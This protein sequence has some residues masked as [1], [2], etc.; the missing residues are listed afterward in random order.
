[1]YVD[2]PFALCS[3]DFGQA[4]AQACL[5]PGLVSLAEEPFPAFNSGPKASPAASMG[6]TTID[7]E[8]C[9]Q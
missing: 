8:V 3:D 6:K 9:N 1:M 5:Q 4:V 2:T 7:Y